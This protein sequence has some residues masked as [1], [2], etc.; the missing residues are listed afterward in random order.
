VRL[1]AHGIAVE[2]PVGWSGRVFSRGQG[3]A[4]LHAGNFTL[5]LDD[6]EFGD[7]S[8]GAMR[9]GA[10]FLALTEYRAGDGLRPGHGL[11]APRRIPRRLDP[12]AL[13]RTGLAHPRAGQVGTQHFFTASGR[14]FCLYVVLA[15]PRAQRRRQLAAL[16][17]VLG[18]LRI[19]ER[20]T[21][22]AP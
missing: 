16:E 8:T 9:D 17:H 5:A 12:T 10:S 20:E 22:A 7:R 19:Q 21:V 11:F 15:G 1:H 14:P 13:K 4:T 2:L 6:G 18:S 3:V